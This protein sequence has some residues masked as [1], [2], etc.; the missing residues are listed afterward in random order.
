[1]LV[2]ARGRDEALLIGESRLV[3]TSLWPAVGLTYSRLGVVRHFTFLPEDLANEPKLMLDEANVT[4]AG[5]NSTRTEVVFLFDAPRS[6]LVLREELKLRLDG[7][8]DAP[9][10]TGPGFS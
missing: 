3:V 1:V 10:R 2:L 6:V 4:V 5:F 8:Q 7:Q 9:R